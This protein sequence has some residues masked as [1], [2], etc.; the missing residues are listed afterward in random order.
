VT[1]ADDIAAR[2][3]QLHERIADA[4]A[5]AGRNDRVTLVAV[6][7]T[8]EPPRI[9]EAYL[10]GQRVFGENRV[11]EG[12]KKIAEL[13]GRMPDAVWHLIGHLQSN[14]ARVA[15]EAF[16][17]VESVDSLALASKLD[18]FAAD[19]DRILPVLIEINVAGEASKSGLSPEE[20]ESV[21]GRLAGLGHLRVRG[22]MT[23]APLVSEPEEAR[24]VFRTLRELR[25]RSAAHFHG[26]EFRD[27]SM[28]MSGDFEVAVEE[29]ATM[30]R[31]GRALFGERP[32]G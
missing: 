26:D 5:R 20:F 12:V 25:D 32:R 4:A 31:I 13:D 14:K 19:E 24:P 16:S 9:E 15:T 18:R 8:V 11:Q 6:S 17:L 22:L 7:K 3:R 21:A 30:V 28:G 2:L 29:G 1:V 10:A 23:V 27:L